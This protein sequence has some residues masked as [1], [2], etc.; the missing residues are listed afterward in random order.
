[1][2]GDGLLNGISSILTPLPHTFQGGYP[3]DSSS[4]E[5]VSAVDETSQDGNAGPDVVSLSPEAIQAARDAEG[6][7]P[8]DESD[9]PSPR[10][11]QDLNEEELQAFL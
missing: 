3:A 1:M 7:V 2:F 10:D 6:E 4:S 5:G 8:G 9:H 11:S